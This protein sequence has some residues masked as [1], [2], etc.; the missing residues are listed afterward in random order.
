MDNKYL[1]KQYVDTGLVL[2]EHQITQLPSWALKTYI[3]KRLISNK[4]NST[5]SGYMRLRDSEL[6]LKTYEYFL[7]DN[8]QQSEFLNTVHVEVLNELISFTDTDKRDDLIK[9]I[10]NHKSESWINA[11]YGDIDIPYI[12]EVMFRYSNNKAYVFNNLDCE[13]IKKFPR[14]TLQF[15]LYPGEYFTQKQELI[16]IVSK[17]INVDDYKIKT[18]NE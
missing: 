11:P 12:L 7:L 5:Y 14:R 18:I 1:I 17:C 13:I 2:P 3:R 16:D 8:N 9:S 4:T 10:I 6:E 15:I